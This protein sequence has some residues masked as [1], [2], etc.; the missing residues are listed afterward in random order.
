MLG[1]NGKQKHLHS[2]TV[3]KLLPGEGVF[4]LYLAKAANKSAF[5][6]HIVGAL[7]SLFKSWLIMFY[8]LEWFDISGADLHLICGFNNLLNSFTTAPTWPCKERCPVSP[9]RL[10]CLT[11]GPVF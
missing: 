3:G 7:L 5:I 10:P 1:E 6:G 2:R 4:H 8:C 9:L 11:F